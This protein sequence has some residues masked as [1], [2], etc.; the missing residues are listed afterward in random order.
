M[1]PGEMEMRIV[2]VVWLLVLAGCGGWPMSVE[3]R[4]PDSQSPSSK[5]E[6]AQAEAL[7]QQRR[8]GEPGGGF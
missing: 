8:A 1:A 4:D 5:L 6:Q 7:R 2:L 3:T